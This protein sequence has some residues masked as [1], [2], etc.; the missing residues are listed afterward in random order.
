MNRYRSQ[1]LPNT[2]IEIADAL[3]GIAVMG[4]VIYH[5]LEHFNLFYP[6]QAYTLACDSDVFSICQMLFSGKM[7]GIF[8]LLFG[9]SFFIM[10]DNQEQQGHDFSLR[11]AWRMILLFI[12]GMVN[13]SFY[14]GDILTTYA[15][16]GLLMIPVA[17]LSSKWLWAITIFLLIQ[18]IEI[19]CI[20][21]G[22]QL[23]V[24]WMWEAYERTGEANMHGTII[25]SAIVNLQEA[26]PTNVG[27]GVYSGRL[28]QT[29][30]LFFLGILVGRYRLLYNEGRN[31]KIWL[32]VL[33]ISLPLALIGSNINAGDYS[34]WTKPVTNFFILLSEVSAVVLLWYKLKGF[35]KALRHIC[36]FGRMSLSNYLLQS[37]IGS[38]LFYGWGLSLYDDLGSTWSLLVGI[39]MIIFQILILRQWNKYHQ[40]GPMETLW[41]KATWINRKQ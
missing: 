40:R 9:L 5:S 3:R 26:F 11:F 17:Y 24:S 35:S 23:D 10:R 20:L 16:M 39:G 8:A 29:L 30:G 15:V 36:F 33:I 14:N 1:R 7:Y 34:I 18:P 19:Y 21:T 41:R 6:N 31:L 4:I 25:Q 12:I 2:R 22:T 13:M 38:F 37:I 32:W 28:T 27:W